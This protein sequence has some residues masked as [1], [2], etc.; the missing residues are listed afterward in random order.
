M[1]RG[2]F[3][4]WQG[5]LF[6]SL[7]SLS[8]LALA[9]KAL[10]LSELSQIAIHNN[11][12]LKT[13]QYA[14]QLAGARLVQA[15][16]WS[17]P[18]INLNN[19]DDHLLT[20]EGE[21]TRSLGFTQAFPIS[22][23]IGKQKNLARV[24]IALALAEIRNAKRLLKGEVANRYY[25]LLIS[26]KRLNQLLELL[27]LNKQLV[28]V[29]QNRFLAAEVSE[30]D[31]N[32]AKL[33]YQR[34]LQE[35]QVLDSL[36]ISQRAELNQLLGREATSPLVLDRQMPRLIQLGSLAQ[37]Q[38]LAIKNRPDMKMTLLSLDRA[39]ANQQLAQAERWADWSVG[40][41]VQQSKIFVEGGQLQNPDRALG[42]N[43]NIPLP[44]L[45]S[46]Q[47]RILEAGVA[48]TQALTKLQALK[49]SIQTE[50]AANYAQVQALQKAL[51]QA[52][53]N[54]LK[55][56]NRN[57]A[58]ARNAYKNGQISLLEVLQVQRQQ[59]ELQ[60]AQLNMLEKY[61]Q[62]LVR[63]CIALGNDNNGP[64]CPYLADMRNNNGF[65]RHSNA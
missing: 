1:K 10:T 18:S 64:L 27:A 59:Y 38:L 2:Y 46:N 51:E 33:E 62:A 48:G 39:K 25:A 54:V 22:G 4:C 11:K 36:R 9:I 47:G 8:G 23:R 63:L 28:K 40:L 30:L 7:L 20:D 41:S 5:L 6:L 19:T 43:I 44:L 34:I 58:L 29:T 32:T 50:I 26:E 55:L 61:S 31:A 45:N 60:V 42:I 15:G 24:D 53:R 3:Y 57:V 17:N 37:L 49:L 52:Q 35:K 12:D 21:Y 13:A 65:S 56:A 14:I 16:L